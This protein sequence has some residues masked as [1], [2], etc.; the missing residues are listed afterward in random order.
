MVGL[1]QRASDCSGVS[2]VPELVDVHQVTGNDA[3][4]DRL[5]PGEV[6]VLEQRLVL[7]P[8]LAEASGIEHLRAGLAQTGADGDTDRVGHADQ[9]RHLAGRPRPRRPHPDRHRHGRLVDQR[10]QVV[11]TLVGDDSLLGVDLEHQASGT[12]V[13]GA[14]DRVFDGRRK[15]VVE[16]ARHLE[17]LDEAGRLHRRDQAGHSPRSP[18]PRH[19]SGR[20]PAHHLGRLP[21]RRGRRSTQPVRLRQRGGGPLLS[22]SDGSLGLLH[23]FSRPDRCRKGRGG[24]NHGVRRVGRRRLPGGHRHSIGGNRG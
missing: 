12:V 10:C 5:L 4:V 24:K 1:A 21:A 7:A 20:R 14:T 18:R 2:G 17:D 19:C 6:G 15:D 3:H 8:D 22:T 16:Q 13:V 9:L 23:G 11:E